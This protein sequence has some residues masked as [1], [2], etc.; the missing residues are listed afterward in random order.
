MGTTTETTERPNP[1]KGWTEG[2]D[3]TLACPHRDLSVCDPCASENVEA[4]EVVG[5]H[6]WVPDAA[7]R[8]EFA[9][10]A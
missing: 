3:G 1:P 7:A 2:H 4:C 9:E 5:A 6:F 8:A 10:I